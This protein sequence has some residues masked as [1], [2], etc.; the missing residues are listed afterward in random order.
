MFSMNFLNVGI[1]F[2]NELLMKYMN[3]IQNSN[4]KHLKFGYYD[5]PLSM[6][7][8]GKMIKENQ[9]IEILDVSG[10]FLNE[11]Y[12]IFEYFISNKTLKTLHIHSVDFCYFE[13]IS[14]MLKKNTGIETLLIFQPK[15]WSDLLRLIFEGMIE[16]EHLKELNFSGGSQNSFTEMDFS[17]LVSGLEGFKKLKKC[18]MSLNPLILIPFAKGLAGNKSIQDLDL[19]FISVKDK[20]LL[21]SFFNIFK[22]N[23]SVEHLTIDSYDPNYLLHL[24]EN[25]N[26]KSLTLEDRIYLK[27]LKIIVDSFLENKT[28]I[29]LKLKGFK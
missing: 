13:G 12:Q 26:L 10:L 24:N 9:S 7:L 6:S 27:E 21:E 23:T 16:N 1:E 5:Q 18:R 17:F 14:N 11:D 3:V 29:K 22:L 19:S 15:N 20:S 8:V 4:I 28:I 25:E 2:S